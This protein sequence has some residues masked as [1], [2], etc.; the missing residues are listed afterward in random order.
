M[1]INVS[2]EKSL[3]GRIDITT[4]IKPCW[5]LT[6]L[7]PISGRGRNFREF[8]LFYSSYLANKHRIL[9]HII[10]ELSE[11]DK[12]VKI[13]FDNFIR[14]VL[15]QIDKEIFVII[16]NALEL[17]YKMNVK[18]MRDLSKYKSDSSNFNFLNLT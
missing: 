5:F 15:S 4:V 18:K 2:S 16:F 13:H 8:D 14:E 6:L 17:N 3:F 1:S 10:K 11:V 12:F 7:S 9:P